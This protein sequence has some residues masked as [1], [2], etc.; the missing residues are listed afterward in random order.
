MISAALFLG[1]LCGP[2]IAQDLIFKDLPGVV[3]QSGPEIDFKDSG[4]TAT[5]DCT[6]A[7]EI[8][9]TENTVP[10]RVYKCRK[11]NITIT[12]DKPPEGY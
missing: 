2:V 1:S 8:Y 10:Q 9:G 3:R 5:P 7:F 4:N 11:G 12:R 6:A